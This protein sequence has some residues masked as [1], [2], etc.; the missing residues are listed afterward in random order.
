MDNLDLDIPTSESRE[1]SLS[2]SFQVKPDALHGSPP[3]ASLRAS[4]NSQAT[5]S[6]RRDCKLT[7][8]V[9]NILL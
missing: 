5:K 3:N 2:V 7:Q 8:K 1:R 4:T 6:Q 9:T